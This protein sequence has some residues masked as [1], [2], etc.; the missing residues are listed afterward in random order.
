MNCLEKITIALL[1]DVI[2]FQV[3]Q[4]SPVVESVSSEGIDPGHVNPV[5]NGE[6]TIFSPLSPSHFNNNVFHEQIFV[7]DY[8]KWLFLI[9]CNRFYVI[10]QMY[11][12]KCKMFF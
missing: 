3:F 12:S 5:A 4:N 9:L 2:Y 8:L 10:L 11:T 1:I 6:F 7:S